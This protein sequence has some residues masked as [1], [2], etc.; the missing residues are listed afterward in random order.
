MICL[1]LFKNLI[2]ILQQYLFV[3]NLEQSKFLSHLWL[4]LKFKIFVLKWFYLQVGTDKSTSVHHR[5][6]QNLSFHSNLNY[7]FI[8]YISL[9]LSLINLPLSFSLYLSLYLFL[10]K[11][12]EKLFHSKLKLNTS[13]FLYVELI[14]FSVPLTLTYTELFHKV[15]FRSG[16]S[17]S[18]ILLKL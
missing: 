5:K 9:S 2:Q 10:L 4:N 13:D 17:K 15:L 3:L 7:F 8:W 16:N 12:K 11:R 1:E 14:S 6:L 18:I